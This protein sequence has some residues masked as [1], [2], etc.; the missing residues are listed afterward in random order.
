MQVV[1]HNNR[2]SRKHRK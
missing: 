1:V 2:C